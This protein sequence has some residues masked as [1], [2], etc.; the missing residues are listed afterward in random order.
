MEQYSMK[1]ITHMRTEAFTATD[2]NKVFL[3]NQAR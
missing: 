1:F 2:Y 3:G